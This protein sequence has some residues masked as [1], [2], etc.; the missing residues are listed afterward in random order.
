MNAQQFYNYIRAH[1]I[2][3]DLTFQ[4]G[5]EQ[6]LD[7]IKDFEG[8][9]D[10]DDWVDYTITTLQELN[11]DLDSVI[12]EETINNN[13]LACAELLRFKTIEPKSFC[14]CRQ[15]LQ[16]LISREPV[17]YVRIDS[18]YNEFMFCNWCNEFGFDELYEIL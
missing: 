8:D 17:K 11:A 18:L 7:F 10:I 4:T 5:T 13:N 14:V 1:H 6:S 12:D 3:Q 16:A 15:C 9:K 2:E